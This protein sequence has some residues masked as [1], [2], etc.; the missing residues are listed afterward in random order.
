M[1][2]GC[3]PTP[4]S[5]T[6]SP[7]R[8]L[9]SRKISC[10][11]LSPPPRILC[12]TWGHPICHLPT[13]APPSSVISNSSL[14][15]PLRTRRGRALLFPGL[16][17]RKPGLRENG[18]LAQGHCTC[19][20]QGRGACGCGA[21]TCLCAEHAEPAAQ[22]NGEQH[23]HTREALFSLQT[24]LAPSQTPTCSSRSGVCKLVFRQSP[25]FKQNLIGKRN[26]AA[27]AREATA[28]RPS[29]GSSAG[30]PAPSVLCRSPVGSTHRAQTFH[31]WCLIL[32]SGSLLSRLPS[33]LPVSRSGS[34][35][36][37]LRA[38][39]L[40]LEPLL[41]RLGTALWCRQP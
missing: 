30:W 28:A 14:Q 40:G 5:P 25:L 3:D 41:A 38:E 29:P 13:G 36:Q 34:S 4:A 26:I 16:Q 10:S 37:A 35:S 32:V 9:P 11:T 20:G 8:A 24:H 6:V 39:Q 22:P 1:G 19:Q 2:G 15:T 23:P 17:M 31:F 33:L 7:Q 27:S 21:L 12:S 18:P